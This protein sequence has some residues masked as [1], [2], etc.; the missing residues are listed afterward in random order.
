M[1]QSVCE[2]SKLNESNLEYSPN[3]EGLPLN[4]NQYNLSDEEERQPQRM[5]ET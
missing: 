3:V 2:E 1:M 5:V 4:Q